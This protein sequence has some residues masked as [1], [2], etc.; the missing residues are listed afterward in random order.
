MAGHATGDGVDAVADLDAVLDRALRELDALVLRLRDSQAVAGHDDDL[1]G[2]GQ[3]QRDASSSGD[4]ADGPAASAAGTAAGLLVAGAEPADDDVDERA[5]HRV[6]HELGEDAAGGADQRAGNDQRDAVEH[7]AR[8]G[9][10]GS[11]EG[12]E[13]G[14]DDRHVGAADRQ[15]RRG[16]PARARGGRSTTQR[17]AGRRTRRLGSAVA[18]AAI[19]EQRV[20][21][22]AAAEGHGRP[23]MRPASLPAATSEPEKVNAADDA[24]PGTS[25]RWCGR[26]AR[27]RRRRAGVARSRPDGDKRGRAAADR[28]EQADQLRHGGHLDP[29]G[30]DQP[31]Q[32]PR[33]ASRRSASSVAVAV[34]TWSAGQDGDRGH[35]T[36]APCRRRRPGCPVAPRRASSSGAGPATKQTAA[37]R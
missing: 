21:R 26:E 27:R 9:Y 4:F 33:P 28:I 23:G 2:V 11:G 25:S 3:L 24:R 7:E 5:V 30:G 15:R 36:R 32:P 16:C 1:A 31:D 20:Q 8:H 6:G 18:A 17:R 10:R 35:D 29:P 12:V 22:A 37:T 19:G 14:D 34:M 13:Q